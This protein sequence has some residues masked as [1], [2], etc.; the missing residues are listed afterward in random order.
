ML[1]L[2]KNLP[3][4]QKTWVRSLD[5][6]NPLE[7]GMATHSSILAWRIP[8]SEEPSRLQS[9][10]VAKSGT[11]L[12]E[13]HFHF[14]EHWSAFLFL[15]FKKIIL[16]YSIIGLQSCFSFRCTGFPG[17]TRDKEPEC[18]CSR[19]ESHG[20]DPWVG[21]IPWRRKWQ[22]TPVLLAGE[23]HGQ[24]SLAGYSPWG[25]KELTTRLS[26]HKLVQQSDSFIHIHI[27]IFFRVFSHMGYFR[28]LN[29]VP[30]AM[31]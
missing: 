30:W 25:C 28:V 29:R 31:Q 1:L 8:Y 21:K 12:S 9:M 13:W 3:V 22:P 27:S 24:R 4:M 26:T 6:E 17:G 16:F 10:G 5:S 19:L 18:Q 23:S 15:L 14:H 2:V 11:W 20:L 7:K